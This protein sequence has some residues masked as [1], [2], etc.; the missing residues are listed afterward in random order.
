[1][2]TH[3]KE[4]ASWLM[5]NSHHKRLNIETHFLPLFGSLIEKLLNGEQ[6]FSSEEAKGCEKIS[7]REGEGTNPALTGSVPNKEA[8]K[9]TVGATL[10]VGI[11][12]LTP[13]VCW[14]KKK[15]WNLKKMFTQKK[16]NSQEHNLQ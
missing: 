8:E 16:K 13:A 7:E 6:K 15:K 2:K 10:P 5:H 11:G 9:G 14:G 4:E 1:M 12:P 3:L